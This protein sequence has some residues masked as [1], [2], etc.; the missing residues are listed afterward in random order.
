M[1]T[2]HLCCAI[3]SWPFACISHLWFILSL[4][5]STPLIWWLDFFEWLI[6]LANVS[7]LF[8]TYIVE[9]RWCRNWCRRELENDIVGGVRWYT[10]LEWTKSHS[11]TQK[12]KRETQLI[13]A[14]RH[15]RFCIW[16]YA[17]IM[18]CTMHHAPCHRPLSF[19]NCNEP[20]LRCP[21]R[22]VL[23]A[24]HYFSCNKRTFLSDSRS[25]QCLATH[26]YYAYKSSLYRPSILAAFLV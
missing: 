15:F 22:L 1:L 23:S 7:Y 3:N 24:N 9:R 4:C 19:V 20:T 6:D 21:H 18:Y 26:I 14:H 17:I 12:K 8:R 5:V 25:T 10:R 16:R 13:F 2:V 11:R